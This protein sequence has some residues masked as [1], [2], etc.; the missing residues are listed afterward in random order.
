MPD[1]PPQSDTEP[2][3]AAPKSSFNTGSAEQ[4]QRIEDLL[5]HWDIAA[6]RDYYREMIV[7]LYKLAQDRPLPADIRL[8]SKAMKELR[9]A[10]NVFAPYHQIRKVSVYGSA[11]TQPGLPEYQ[12]ARHFAALM[13]E[14]GFMTITGGGEGIMGAAQEGAGREDSF[15]LNISLPFEQAANATIDGD[16]KLVNFKYFFTRKVNFLKHS[17]AF[18]LCPGGFGTM[19]EGF[20][21]L[22]LMQ[23]GKAPVVP[24]IF[25]DAP[26]GNFWTT[27][28]R[29]LREHLLGDG[30]ISEMDFHLLT[31]TDDP[32]VAR[33]EIVNF[34]YNYHS[35]RFIG[36]TLV[37]RMQREVPNGALPRLQEDFQDILTQP[38]GLTVCAALK[39]E[40]H[41]PEL[42]ELPR[43]C[44]KFDRRSYGRLRQL[45]DRINQF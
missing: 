13:T 34:Y 37:I 43:L 29:Y 38:D 1:I 11:R 39:A 41:Q 14:S 20:E 21:T 27:F 40:K 15:A 3:A 42:A 5:D 22:T 9:Y 28:V 35:Y 4:D 45:I 8:L 30:L 31:V 24:L 32:E 7:N 44:V 23:T 17:D 2:R 26:H 36:D 12:Q 10:D 16:K 18:V 6:D 19:D 33:K 25:L